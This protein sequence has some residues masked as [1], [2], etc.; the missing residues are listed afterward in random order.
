[1]LRINGAFKVYVRIFQGPLRDGESLCIRLA[2]V[3][4]GTG[5]SCHSLTQ[6]L[7]LPP[8]IRGYFEKAA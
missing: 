5:E 2:G 6:S 7:Y 1:M 3:Q 8:Y 4:T